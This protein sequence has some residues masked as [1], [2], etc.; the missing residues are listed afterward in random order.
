[1]KGSLARHLSVQLGQ[2]SFKPP[3]HPINS[4]NNNQ[5]NN[6]SRFQ[7]LLDDDEVHLASDSVPSISAKVLDFDFDA[8]VTVDEKD[9]ILSQD[10][11]WYFSDFLFNFSY[12]FFPNNF[13]GFRYVIVV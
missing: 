8:D 13:I 10:F 11:F 7:N 3:I 5:N 1:M 6:G 12:F 4:N 2:I 9:N